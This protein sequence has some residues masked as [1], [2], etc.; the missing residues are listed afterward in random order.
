VK[1]EKAD[2]SQVRNDRF[3]DRIFVMKWMC[4]RCTF[5]LRFL[6]DEVLE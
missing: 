6:H 1:R 3:E 4:S 5:F 2:S